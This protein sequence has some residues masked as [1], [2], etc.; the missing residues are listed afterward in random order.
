MGKWICTKTMGKWSSHREEVMTQVISKRELRSLF[1][2]GRKLE[3]LAC[4]VPMTAPQPRTVKARFNGR[5]VAV[6]WHVQGREVTVALGSV[7]R[8][9]DGERLDIRIES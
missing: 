1:Y 7:L 6:E 3:L 5:P 8:V 4:Y 2:V 9:K